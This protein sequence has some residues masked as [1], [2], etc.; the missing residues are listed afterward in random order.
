MFNNKIERE[1]FLKNY[2]KWESK[3]R[4]NLGLY[5]NPED[6]S[7]ERRTSFG[8]VEIFAYPFKNGAVVIVTECGNEK[9]YNLIIPETDNFNPF[10]QHSGRTPKEFTA[11]NLSGCSIGTIVKYMTLRKGEI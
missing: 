5:D 6:F 4:I 7:D 3:S 10:D 1:A 2:K 8:I 9:R 11:Y